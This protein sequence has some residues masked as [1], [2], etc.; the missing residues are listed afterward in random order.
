[1]SALLGLLRI[2]IDRSPSPSRVFGIANVKVIRVCTRSLKI[3]GAADAM[4]SISDKVAVVI[5][6]GGTVH[7]RGRCSVDS[8]IVL[9][10][11][12]EVTV[13]RPFRSIGRSSIQV[14]GTLTMF[15]M[16]ITCLT[17]LLGAIHGW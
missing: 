7:K 11:E 3:D 15:I 4:T 17:L 14:V 13:V 6:E 10:M 1:M 12:T 8:A 9:A 5:A 16:K 2:R